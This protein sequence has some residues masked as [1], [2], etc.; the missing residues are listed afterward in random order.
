MSRAGL[1]ALLLIAE[2]CAGSAGDESASAP[3]TFTDVTSGSGIAPAAAPTSASSPAT[4]DF[5]AAPFIGGGATAGDIDGDGLYDLVL[6]PGA[7]APAV[8]YRNRGGLA[9][10]RLAADANGD[11]LPSASAPALVDLDNDGDPDLVLTGA[12][13]SYLYENVH[14]RFALRLALPGVASLGVLPTDV[15]GDGLLDLYFYAHRTD[16]APEAAGAALLHN[17]GNFSFHDVTGAWGIANSGYTWA[18]AAF[19]WDE[20]GM[21]DIYVANDTSTPDT[22]GAAPMPGL[23]VPADRLFHNELVDGQ[24]R[25]RDVAVEA[26]LA[27]PR[28]SMNVVVGDFDGDDRFDLFISNWGRNPLLLGRA[29][30]TFVDEGDQRGLT[31]VWMVGDDCPAGA[32]AI[33]C[34]LTTWGAARF[35]ANH[36]GFDDL[37]M[38][39]GNVSGDATDEAQPAAVWRGDEQGALTK[40]EASLGTMA[41]RCLLPVDLD[42]DGDLDL[43]ITLHDG[44]AVV[45]RNDAPPR[46]GW[47]RVRLAGSRS[48]RDGV[49]AVVIARLS[50]GRVIRRLVG[51]GGLVQGWAPS[52]A[53]IVTN[54]VPIAELEVRWPSGAIDRETNP[55]LDR[56]VT[57]EER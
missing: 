39:R 11:P 52:E 49:G 34:L 6:S 10:E 50:S 9:F 21:P 48:N 43:V 37:V 24:R 7:G 57:L 53:H 16:V 56:V 19:D 25:F 45:L 36:D 18:A 20:D 23:P 51:A 15:D 40:V 12:S 5:P 1:A 26:G 31:D 38:V 14:G 55:P 17:D 22:A 54:G 32:A 46:R 41:A 47:L 35:D 33:M 30:G 8:L 13:G 4:A 2:A 3:I 27:T 29:D 42:G 44:A 28:A